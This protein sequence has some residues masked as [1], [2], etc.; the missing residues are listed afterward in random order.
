MP[1]E[2]S[3]H[4]QGALDKPPD[5][6]ESLGLYSRREEP[7]EEKSVPIWLLLAV[8]VYLMLSGQR[9]IWVSVGFT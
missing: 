5:K 8:P 4:T 1:L 9:K 3:G 6:Q 2:T 7:P